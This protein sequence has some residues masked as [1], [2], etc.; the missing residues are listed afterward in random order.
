[1][2]APNKDWQQRQ[3]L[4]EPPPPRGRFPKG[5]TARDRMAR[6]LLTKR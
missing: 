4:R 5:L 6:T 2:I 3:A 1:L